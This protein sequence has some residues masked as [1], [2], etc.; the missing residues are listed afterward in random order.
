MGTVLKYVV[1]FLVAA[2]TAGF[3][4]YGVG[5]D[6]GYRQHEQIQ[7]VYG[8]DQVR[9]LLKENEQQHITDLVRASAEITKK[10]EGGLFS[11][12]WV[13]Y[14][15]CKILNSASVATVKDVKL[16]LDFLSK[17]DAVIN[18]EEI[19]VY[20]FIRPNREYTYKQKVKWPQE[21]DKYRITI[22]HAGYD[23][24]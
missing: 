23:Q 21:A 24:R 22:E 7:K 3:V 13:H 6:E 4:G 9:A 15:N 18:S 5:I 17:T 11:T 19:N 1:V 2:A 10:D 14:L 8:M 12:K 16:R 20:E